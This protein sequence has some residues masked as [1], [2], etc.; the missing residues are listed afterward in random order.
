[1][2][3]DFNSNILSPP[4]SS[5]A[6]S[7]R[8]YPLGQKYIPSVRQIICFMFVENSRKKKCGESYC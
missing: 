5:F 4:L 2:D 6:I 8:L 7:T 3:V 1:M